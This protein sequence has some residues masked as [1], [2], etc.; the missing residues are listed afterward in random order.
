MKNVIILIYLLF[1]SNCTDAQSRFVDHSSLISQEL[2]DVDNPDTL[3]MF[4][5]PITCSWGNQGDW[6]QLI[7]MVY[8]KN[9]S[10]AYKAIKVARQGKWKTTSISTIC[11][12]PNELEPKMD[13]WF[14]DCKYAISDILES[15]KGEHTGHYVSLMY[16]C[17]DDTIEIPFHNAPGSGHIVGFATSP[18]H[19]LYDLFALCMVNASGFDFKEVERKKIKKRSA[20]F[21][22]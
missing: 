14:S 4:I 15:R 10:W 2:H 16:K 3:L 21:D 18:H 5:N 8:K 17:H 6:A 11:S 22:H 12:F 7:V 19:V 13:S 20:P 9:G 1:V